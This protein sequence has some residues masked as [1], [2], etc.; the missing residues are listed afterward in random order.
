[1]EK[2]K[3][4]EMQA[5]A[6]QADSTTKLAGPLLNHRVQPISSSIPTNN[7]RTLSPLGRS[8]ISNPISPIPNSTVVMPP[9]PELRSHR[10]RHGHSI[11][12]HRRDGHSVPSHRLES[13]KGAH[14]LEPAHGDI[15]LKRRTPS[16]TGNDEDYSTTIMSSIA[17]TAP[18]N[19]HRSSSRHHHRHPQHPH[20]QHRRRTSTSRSRVRQE[21]THDRRTNGQKEK[22]HSKK[23]DSNTPT[24][25][26][27]TNKPSSRYRWLK[28]RKE[29]PTENKDEET[30]SKKSSKNK[31]KQNDDKDGVETKK[32]SKEKSSSSDNNRVY[33]VPNVSTVEE[34]KSNVPAEETKV[35][36]DEPNEKETQDETGEEKNIYMVPK[37]EENLDEQ[38]VERRN[39]TKPKSSHAKL[40]ST[41]GEILDKIEEDPR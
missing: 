15:I 22:S 8:L 19:H 4:F 37:D 7:H 36:N 3:A 21:S 38:P 18:H 23:K 30:K 16:Q 17:Q 12:T 11:G 2:I 29:T 6:A 34:T 1:M 33:G 27:P 14:V 13:R 40:S 26:T 5:A 39:P 24:E 31:K 10:S 41:D 35:S 28:G 32:K 20:Q 9:S 25:T